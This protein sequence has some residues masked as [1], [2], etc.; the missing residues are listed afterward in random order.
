MGSLV[1]RG[2]A[3]FCG[4]GLGNFEGGVGEI[5]SVLV[6]TVDGPVF[7]ELMVG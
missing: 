3:C 7:E 1:S 2:G 4:I 6:E 5:A